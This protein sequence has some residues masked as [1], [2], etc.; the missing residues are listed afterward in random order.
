MSVDPQ[1]EYRPQSTA[2]D[3]R[4]LIST[5][6]SLSKSRGAPKIPKYGTRIQ[7]DIGFTSIK[8]TIKKMSALDF[9]QKNNFIKS[10]KMEKQ[11]EQILKNYLTSNVLN[12]GKLSISNNQ[13]V[14]VKE[15]NLM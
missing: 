7:D 14:S 8:S 2:N 10:H 15:L 11:S 9:T 5:L 4:S 6:K 13:E 12:N 1:K 3:Y